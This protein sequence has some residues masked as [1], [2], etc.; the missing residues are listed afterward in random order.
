MRQRDII[1]VGNYDMIG[2]PYIHMRQ[3]FF[4]QSGYLYI[5]TAR[6]RRASR[7]IMRYYHAGSVPPERSLDYTA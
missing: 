3:S 7:M 4:Q 1:A 2:K 6:E 5:L